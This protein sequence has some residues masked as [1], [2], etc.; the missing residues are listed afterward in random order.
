[1]EYGKGKALFSDSNLT[2]SDGVW[3]ADSGSSDHLC[4]RREWFRNFEDFDVRRGITVSD[5]GETYAYGRGEIHVL[6][7]TGNKWIERTLKSVLYVPNNHVNLLS[8]TKVLDNGHGTR[9][10][11][12]LFEIL[13]GD[14]VVA[15][16]ERCGSLFKMNFKVIVPDQRNYS[17]TN[18]AV[19]SDPLREW[20]ERFAHQNVAHVK[21]IQNDRNIDFLDDNSNCDGCAYGK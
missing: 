16:G 12:N 3:F 14:Q 21:K 18:M 4:N 8:E 15:T 13:D 19:K 2:T 1:M 5:G 7:F 10:I 11:S 17:S 6:S 20:H 9:A